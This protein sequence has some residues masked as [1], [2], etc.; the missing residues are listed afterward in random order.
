[1]FTFA[2]S[3]G[4]G[5]T[6]TSLPLFVTYAN[7]SLPTPA[8]PFGEGATQFMITEFGGAGIDSPIEN[9]TQTLDIVPEPA[10]A[11]LLGI[12]FV[13]LGILSRNR[14]S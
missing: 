5:L 12:G 7:G 3:G 6:G 11:F 13:S 8:G 4:G 10:T 1:M 9:V 14:P 2:G